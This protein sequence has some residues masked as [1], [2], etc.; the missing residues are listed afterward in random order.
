MDDYVTYIH[1]LAAP[2]SPPQRLY[3][4]LWHSDDANGYGQDDL[5]ALNYE[6]MRRANELSNEERAWYAEHEPHMTELR[7]RIEDGWLNLV[8]MTVR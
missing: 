7:Q 1:P 5:D 2:G 4:P 3:L 6:L 8:M